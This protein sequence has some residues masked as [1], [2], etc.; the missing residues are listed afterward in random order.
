[1]TT[2]ITYEHSETGFG[3]LMIVKTVDHLIYISDT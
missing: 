2:A 1:M 3:S